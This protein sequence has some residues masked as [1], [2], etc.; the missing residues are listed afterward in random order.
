MSGLDII[1]I[2]IANVFDFTYVAQVSGTQECGYEYR[3]RLEVSPKFAGN[4][5]LGTTIIYI[6]KI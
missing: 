1:H 5:R 4:D 3:I 6:K 2:F